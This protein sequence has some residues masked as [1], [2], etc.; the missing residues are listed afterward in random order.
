MYTK[1]LIEAFKK[2]A[3]NQMVY[4]FGNTESDYVA[5]TLGGCD[6]VYIV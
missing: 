4:G 2:L 6:Q 1:L 3:P 5:F